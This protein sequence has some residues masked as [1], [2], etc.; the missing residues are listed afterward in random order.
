MSKGSLPSKLVEPKAVKVGK[1]W[2]VDDGE[3]NISA[4]EEE[5]P[6][7]VLLWGFYPRSYSQPMN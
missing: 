1:Q 4:E 7:Y 3:G 6:S 2:E 5:T